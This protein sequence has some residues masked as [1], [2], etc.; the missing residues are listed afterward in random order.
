MED[1]RMLDIAT[2]DMAFEAYGAN[3][4][5]LFA[6]CGRALTAVMTDPEKIEATKSE[7]FSV[8][9][10]DLESLLFDYLSELIYL[11]DAKGLVFSSFKVRVRGDKEGYTLSCRAEGEI[12]DRSKHEIKTEVKA[13]TYHQ[14]QI[15]ELP[16]ERKW[17]AQVVLDT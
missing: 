11:K 3:M 16:D 4:E 7:Q 15:Q 8:A 14:M 13:A 2:A 6:N 1:Y 12:L 10:H 9:G 17:R 5:E